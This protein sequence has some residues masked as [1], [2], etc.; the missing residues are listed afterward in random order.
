M[1]DS[2]ASPVAVV[3]VSLMPVTNSSQASLSQSYKN[4]IY[5]C[6]TANT[7]MPKIS[8]NQPSPNC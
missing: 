7:T 4:T 2:E 8:T 5:L 6:N 1:N 3:G